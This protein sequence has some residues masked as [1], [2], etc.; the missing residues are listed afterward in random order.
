[1]ASNT[2]TSPGNGDPVKDR[3][4]PFDTVQHN[5]ASVSESANNRTNGSFDEDSESE[6]VD[7]EIILAISRPVPFIPSL[8]GD[9]QPGQHVRNAHTLSYGDMVNTAHGLFVPAIKQDLAVHGTKSIAHILFPSLRH[10]SNQ[11]DMSV[12]ILEVAM[13]YALGLARMSES[14]RYALRHS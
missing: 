12:E 13:W 2:P 6:S 5:D 11:S 9:S 8:G 14:G 7:S 4:S 10:D 1:M 3:N